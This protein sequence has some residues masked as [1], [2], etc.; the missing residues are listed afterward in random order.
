M[1]SAVSDAAGAPH[2]FIL[3][4]EATGSKAGEAAAEALAEA[5]VDA[6]YGAL[7]AATLE[8]WAGAS[9]DNP[10]SAE[11]ARGPGLECQDCFGS[12]LWALLRRVWRGAVA[13]A[14]GVA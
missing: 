5:A 8:E 6:V 10:V 13:V 9:T 14:P 1:T 4:D 11:D 12:M 2:P 3:L 7:V